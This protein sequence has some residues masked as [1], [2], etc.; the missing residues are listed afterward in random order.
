MT[1][2]MQYPPGSLIRVR[3]RDW[4]VEP[5]SKPNF[6]HLRPLAG[7][8]HEEAYVCPQIERIE[9]AT[10]P[11]PETNS[12]GNMAQNHLLQSAMRLGLR[13][14]AG[15]FRSFG[16]IA[17][18]P[19]IYQ[20]VP[21]LMAL[22]LSTIR[23]L[24][25]DDVGIG[26]TIE[27]G[28]IMRELIDRAEVD[29]FC[30]LCPPNLTEQWQTELREHFHIE[31]ELVTPS[32]VKYLE[33]KLPPNTSLFVHHPYTIVSLD[34]IKSDRHSSAF[35]ANAPNLIVVDEAHTCTSTGRGKHKRY[36]L[37]RTLA[38]DAARHMLLLTATPHS[39]V[40]ENFYNLLSL[41]DPKY[42]RFDE[43]KK[44]ERENMRR[45]LARHIVQ[46]RRKDIDEWSKNL[47]ENF[48]PQRLVA[49]SAYKLK[50]EWSDFFQELLDSCRQF[51]LTREEQGQG[52]SWYAALALMRCM[53]SSPASALSALR[54]RLENLDNQDFTPMGEDELENELLDQQNEETT[55]DI[56][57]IVEQS[58]SDEAARLQY[59]IEKCEALRSKGRDPKLKCLLKQ[60][61][62]LIAEGYSPI[63]F[64]QYIST[65]E[66]LRDALRKHYKKNYKEDEIVAITGRL[67]PEERKEEIDQLNEKPQRIL[68]ATNCLS[69]GINLQEAFNA[70]IHYDLAWNP[71]RHEQREGRVDRFGQ[72]AKTVK[73][74]LMYA[75]DSPI[76]GFILDIILRKGKRIREALGVQVPLP[77][78]NELLSR[79]VVK[80]IIMRKYNEVKHHDE[81]PFLPGFEDLAKIDIEWQNA[82]EKAKRTATTFAQNTLRPEE[83]FPEWELQSVQLGSEE[84]L[85]N[86]LLAACHHVGADLQ[87]ESGHYLLDCKLFPE[88]IASQWAQSGLRGKLKLSFSHRPEYIHIQRSHPIITTLAEHLSEGAIERSAGAL[89]R[90][91]VTLISIEKLTQPTQI[92]FLRLRHQLQFSY[93]QKQRHIMAEE[94]L[95]LIQ[96]GT[97]P[98]RVLTAAEWE[99]YKQLPP[100]GNINEKRGSELVGKALERFQ[101]QGEQLSLIANQRANQLLEDHLRVR[102]ASRIDAGSV[103]IESFLPMDLVALSILQPKL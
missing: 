54:T 102:E 96:E 17:V 41:I 97:A 68:I 42:A 72:K 53:G 79:A 71:T 14:G 52:F 58:H 98:Y 37:L 26:K 18:R 81:L 64:C 28:L 45:Q 6:L 61:D 78:N 13:A 76:D 99:E 22:K 21:L 1:Q 56:E 92:L 25:A 35:I 95:M 66:Y 90:S 77:E 9:S 83:V 57:P 100:S 27:A 33:S 38:A 23:L 47:E 39:G 84:E 12:L 65:A 3:Q 34:Y 91:S 62:T 2:S 4:V 63:I 59:L 60:C 74:L 7:G 31:A 51:A 30:V 67:T 48:F 50:G 44:N 93:A 69:E 87:E 101:S 10:F 40:D 94:A 43:L 11:L 8:N 103:H 16:N 24:I 20:L 75:E 86:F 85:K 32:S 5:N 73:C 82:L 55:S 49:E 19:R 70:V 80:A 15:P 89:P 36:E 29:R 88:A 46:R